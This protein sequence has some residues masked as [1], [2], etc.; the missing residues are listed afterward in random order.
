[1]G[2]RRVSGLGFTLIE[3][4]VVVAIITLLVAILLPCL[5]RARSQAREVK[6][7]SQLRE[8][9]RGFCFYFADYGD[10]FPACSYGLRPDDDVEPPTW[11]HLI[12]SYWLG[13]LSNREISNQKGAELGLGRCP[14]LRGVRRQNNREWEWEYS[15]KNLGYGYNRYWLGFDQFDREPPTD[16]N[17]RWVFWRRLGEVLRPSECLL[18]ADCQQRRSTRE[19]TYADHVTWHGM[20]RV[21]G[22]VD[23]RHGASGVPTVP[24]T[25]AGDTSYY[26]NGSGNVLWVDGHVTARS[27]LQIN[28]I[29]EWRHLWDPLQGVGGW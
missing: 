27:S 6:C 17:A 21:G 15:V 8:Y 19:K 16:G 18:V 22:G 5:A 12:E 24:S 9:G 13:G 11:F 3:L 26:L 25:Y 7:R 10:T 2:E 29:V 23:T 1:M 4:L 14:E 20:A 28:D